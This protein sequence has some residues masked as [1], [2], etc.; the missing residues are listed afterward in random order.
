[1]NNKNYRVMKFF[2]QVN[3]PNKARGYVRLDIRGMRG[4]IIV[5]AEGLGDAKSSSEVYLYKDK[6]N[7]LKLG[8]INNKK[9][10]IKKSLTF[11]S[12]SSVEDY[13][14]CAVVQDKKIVLYTNLFNSVALEQIKKLEYSDED[15]AVLIEAED[16]TLQE[17]VEKAEPKSEN[18]ELAEKKE[19]EEGAQLED[20][21]EEKS[22]KTEPIEEKAENV[23]KA[24]KTEKEE[25]VEKTEAIEEKAEK[26]EAAEEKP[27]EQAAKGINDNRVRKESVSSAVNLDAEPNVETQARKYK[28]K[29]EESLYNALKE[30]KKIEP[31]SVQIKDFN[32]WY[33][34]YDETGIKNGFLPYYNQ[35]ISSYYPYPVSNRVTTCSG[36]MKKY[37]HYIF[38]IFKE[39]GEIVK[40]VYGVPGEFTKEEQPYK[41]ITG[42][43]NW[44]YSNKEDKSDYGYW[45]AFVN[46]RTGETTEPPEIVL[47]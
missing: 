7:K 28:N 29:F 31:L 43:K 8:D 21:K 1:M 33:I 18:E 4:N 46:P 25:K 42:F 13:N 20:T 16:K 36:L 10:M 27:I 19:R 45:L 44:S 39:K 6:T 11:G 47:S 5:S 35:I 9:G 40:F 14:T 2:E 3:K 12:D 38:G 32:W 22:A 23:E 34:P 24:E 26:T 17:L 37:G 41:G 30:Y 15:D